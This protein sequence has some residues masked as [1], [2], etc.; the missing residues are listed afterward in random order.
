MSPNEIRLVRNTSLAVLGL[1]TLR[2]IGAAWTPLT[3]DEAYYWTWSKHLS[4][5]YYDHPPGVAVII[6]L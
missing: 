3:F 2:L 5:G 1:V 4:F 6:R